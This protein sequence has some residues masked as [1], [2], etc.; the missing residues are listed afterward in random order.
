[1][2]RFSVLLLCS[3]C[4][5][6]AFSAGTIQDLQ[7]LLDQN[8]FAPAAL[9]G[10]QL[11]VEQPD[12]ARVQ[13]LTAYAYQM[14]KQTNRAKALYENLI[15]DYPELPEPRNNLAMIY[16]AGGDSDKA[17]QLLI[18][19]LNTNSSYS[20]A[21]KNLG[22]I[23]RGIAS[24]TYRQAVSESN[25]P[26]VSIA[27]IELAA[28]SRLS[29]ADQLTIVT[30]PAAS[31][32]VNKANV[33][34]LLIEQVKNWAKAWQGKDVPTYT[35]FYSADHRPGF[36]THK[37]WVE[38]R[39]KRIMRPGAIKVNVS[40]IEIRAQGENRAIIDFE[41]T[42]YSPNYSDKVLKRL[43]FRRIGSNWK[44]SGERVISVL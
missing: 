34:T 27:N 36:N 43:E 5:K 17:S 19:A 44:I 1:M 25:S 42:Y 21:Y 10:D 35:S 26:E 3:L 7:L 9:T 37:S 12:N 8:L 14:D 18:D 29:S 13:F 41:Q 40:D 20:T 15:R 32:V 11:L 33:Q 16:L 24:E 2:R 30:R 38:H 4:F 22:R 31:S 39:R 28:L 6:P 23:Y